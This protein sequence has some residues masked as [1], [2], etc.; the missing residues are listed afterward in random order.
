MSGEVPLPGRG[1]STGS[2]WP[3]SVP[4]HPWDRKKRGEVGGRVPSYGSRAVVRILKV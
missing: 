4:E 2:I 1:M 3:N